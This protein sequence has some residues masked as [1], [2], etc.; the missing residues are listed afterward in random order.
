M[1][2]TFQ[3]NAGFEEQQQGISQ[4][5]RGVHRDSKSSLWKTDGKTWKTCS[6]EVRLWHGRKQAVQ[7][8]T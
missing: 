1:N 8:S 4:M 2:F 7:V 5:Q 6:L 3:Q